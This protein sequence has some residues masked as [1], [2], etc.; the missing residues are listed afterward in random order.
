MK[1]ENNILNFNIPYER[2]HFQYMIAKNPNYFGNISGSK[3]KENFKLIADT[4]FEQ[5]SCVGYNPDTNLMEASFAIKKPHGYGGSLCTAG[6]LEY[7]RF[8]LDFHDG[9][10]FIDQGSVAVNVHDIPAQ[11]DC[12]GKTIF[13]LKYV[14]TLKKKTN[15]AS[16]C[17]KPILP[18]LRAILSWHL[19]PPSASPNWKPVWGN[20]MDGDIQLKPFWKF[21][22]PKAVDLSTYFSLA[23]SSPH[24][25]S[26]QLTEITGVNI[27]QLM[28][29]ELH[30]NLSILS[31]KYTHLK[32]PASRFA[33]KEIYNMV[34]YPSSTITMMDKAL[35]ADLEIDIN[36]II[37]QIGTTIPIEKT[38]ANI[39]Y[40]ELVCFGLDYNTESIVATIKIKK[41]N[42]YSGDLCHAGSKEYIAFWIDWNDECSW[43][44]LNTLT[45][46]VHDI[47]LM[48][49]ALYYQVSLPLNTTYHKKNCHKPNI[50]RI[51][52]VL[53]WNIP[54]SISNPDKLEFYGNRRD[55]HI[56]LKPGTS[57]FPGE[58][59]PLFNILGGIDVAH[60]NDITGLTNAEAFFAYNGLQVPSEAPFGGI[61]VVNGPS[62][63]GYKYRIKI[64]NLSKGTFAYAMNQFTV[65]GFLPYAPW[66]QYTNQN[67]DSEGFYPYLAHEKNTL[68][69]LA[70]FNP[71]TDD[72]FQIELEIDSI[73]GVFSK[74]IQLDNTY[75]DIKLQ[76]DDEDDC[77]HY[78]KGDVIT[79][80]YFVQDQH[81]SSWGL[82]NTWGIGSENGTTNTPSLP[83]TPFNIATVTN[84]Y[85]CGSVSLWAIDK[86]I[87][88]SQQVG[89]YK[90]ISYNICLQEK[91]K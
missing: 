83:G 32:V 44:Y 21:P 23:L 34:K 12:A 19:N 41:E 88:D 91:K 36:P 52:G 3:W 38:I 57:L 64:I 4:T 13:P 89:L 50:I 26:Q 9:L 85:P 78:T 22:F 25:S 56:Q 35:L 84:A 65:V 76:V 75:P 61:I 90:T 33:Y 2:T 86:T 82:E 66:V 79:G 45:L 47:D 6:S 72:K 17:E 74:A 48:G 69:I 24:L 18:T 42:G 73:T 11:E 20:V 28:E 81:I 14:A 58:V 59:A 53:S 5:L 1:A 46:N 40:E 30:T 62:F 8:Y 31:Q 29:P 7:I 63:P 70:R 60:I 37:D 10:G 16:S 68:N 27:K 43:Q 77:T 39:D 67:T 55:A 80:H 51:R 87:Y 15:K 54:P 71:G 49:E